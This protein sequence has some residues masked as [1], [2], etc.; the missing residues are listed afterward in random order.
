MKDKTFFFY[1]LLYYTNLKKKKITTVFKYH[2]N[3]KKENFKIY[4]QRLRHIYFSCFVHHWTRLH[5]VAIMINLCEVDMSSKMSNL[6]QTK[7][8]SEK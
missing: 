7:L 5:C 2:I 3:S 6:L 1:S 8:S 4:T